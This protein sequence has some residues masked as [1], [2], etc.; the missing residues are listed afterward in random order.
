VLHE[1]ASVADRSFLFSLFR[2]DC[3]ETFDFGDAGRFRYLAATISNFVFKT[4]DV[5]TFCAQSYAFI[6]SATSSAS[7]TTAASTGVTA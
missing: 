2:H 3:G 1:Q 5:V 6:V 7:S 4:S